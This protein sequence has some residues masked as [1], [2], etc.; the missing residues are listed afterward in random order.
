MTLEVRGGEDGRGSCSLVGDADRDLGEERALIAG[1]VGV[2]EAGDEGAS[3][4]GEDA[5]VWIA[6][7]SGVARS[8]GV[9]GRVP[10]SLRRE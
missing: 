1:E 8:C 3:D 5:D 10:T 4:D 2:E 6:V 7:G 9:V